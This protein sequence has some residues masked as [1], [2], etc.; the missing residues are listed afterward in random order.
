MRMP[1]AVELFR[2]M[3][4]VEPP[5]CVSTVVER[6]FPGY[7]KRIA[8]PVG[9][10]MEHRFAFFHWIKC[11]RELIHGQKTGLPVN[12]KDFAGPDL[13]TWDWHDDC[14]GECDFNEN[15][16]RRLNQESDQ[17]LA[18]F[19]WAGLRSLNDGHIAP[20][21]WLNSLGNVYI[22]QKQHR[23][24]S[25]QDRVMKDRYGKPHHIFYFR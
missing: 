13:V 7:R 5:G 24:C 4:F 14:G 11:K 3:G 22:V 20:A 25:S 2:K 10:V 12:D 8:V 15:Q 16:L 23:H 19:C 17:E 6:P 18:L 9:F 1:L 21:V